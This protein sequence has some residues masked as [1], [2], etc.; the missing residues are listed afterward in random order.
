LW[1]FIT[2][3]SDHCMPTWWLWSPKDCTKCS[4]QEPGAVLSCHVCRENE[5]GFI[6]RNSK[7]HLLLSYLSSPQ[8][9][10]PGTHSLWSKYITLCYIF[11]KNNE[12]SYE[13]LICATKNHGRRTE[14]ISDPFFF[15]FLLDIF[16]IYISKVIPFPS[17]P[18]E[19]SP[20]PSPPPS[21]PTYPLLLPCPGLPLHWGKEPSQD[22]GPFLPLMSNKPILC[23]IYSW[24]HGPLNC[25]LWLVV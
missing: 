19:K 11:L 25:T 15:T 3:F 9:Y 14:M 16:F 6:C 8:V 20:I 12:K 22:Q 4:A 18:C 24:S 17:F 10:I 13:I 23:Y 5:G 21:S 7:C 1:V 2:Y